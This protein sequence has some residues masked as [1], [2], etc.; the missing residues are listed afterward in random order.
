MIKINQ[1]K[2]LNI[3]LY[4]QFDNYIGIISTTFQLYDVR[5]QIKEECNLKKDEF[6]KIDINNKF[7]KIDLH[8]RIE[9]TG[10][11]LPELRRFEIYLD[12][13]MS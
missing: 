9:R 5:C 11:S 10:K 7:Y 6:Y 8:G 12:R 2:D 1:E 13:L 3:K 4:D